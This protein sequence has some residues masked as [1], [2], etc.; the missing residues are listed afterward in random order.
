MATHYDM[1]RL[2]EVDSTQDLATA[3][4]RRRNRPVLVVA[5]RQVAGRG[6][7]GRS[8]IEPDHGLY[9]SYAFECDW[10]A[11]SVPILALCTAIAVRRAVRDVLGLGVRFRWPNDLYVR[12]RKVGGILPDVTGD[13][14]TIGCGVNL[15]WSD[16]PAFASGLLD[17]APSDWVAPSLAVAWVEHFRA[18]V[19]DGPQAWPHAEYTEAC[20]TIGQRVTWD[21]GEGVATG[22][23]PDG[24]LSVEGA[25]GVVDVVSGDVHLLGHD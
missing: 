20:D 16:P 10:P 5:D 21:G 12:Q 4:A 19:D 11:E 25:E 8:W 13:I 9:S 7:Q 6:R 18:I 2:P 3:A 17:S 14:V 15:T 1:M 24:H 23:R 22:I